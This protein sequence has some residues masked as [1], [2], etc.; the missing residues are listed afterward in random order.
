[1]I[2]DGVENLYFLNPD[3]YQK[4]CM[5]NVQICEYSCDGNNNSNNVF[6]APSTVAVI[7]GRIM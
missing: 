1:M 5:L 2:D 7:S 4:K 3:V 6:Y